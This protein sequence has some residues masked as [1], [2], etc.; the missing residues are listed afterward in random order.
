VAR[1][2]VRVLI[3]D[4]LKQLRLAARLIVLDELVEAEITESEDGRSAVRLA[5]VVQPDLILLDIGLPELNG[6]EA[7]KQIR[8]VSPASKI[9]FV[10]QN[11]DAEIRDAALEIGAEAYVLK[12]NARQ[13]LPS[14]IRAAL[15][16]SSLPRSILSKGTLSGDESWS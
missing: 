13:E 12:M 14:V 1:S 8:E 10:T 6:I 2:P 16:Q 4:D 9:V 11:D 7:A 15:C 5:Q 3:V